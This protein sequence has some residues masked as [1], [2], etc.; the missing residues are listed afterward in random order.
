MWAMW[1]C[2][3]PHIYGSLS[4]DPLLLAS[5]DSSRHRAL[6]VWLKE[7]R[8]LLAWR[9]SEYPEAFQKCMQ[10]NCHFRHTDRQICCWMSLGEV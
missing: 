3:T 7:L 9:G 5:L 4:T 10:V 1:A 2:T 8:L 6:N